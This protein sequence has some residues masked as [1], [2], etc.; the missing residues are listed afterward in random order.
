[1]DEE[2]K[3]AQTIDEIADSDACSACGG[4][5]EITVLGILLRCSTCHGVVSRCPKCGIDRVTELH[6]EDCPLAIAPL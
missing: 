2:V 5:G 4:L 3:E 6:K 1:M